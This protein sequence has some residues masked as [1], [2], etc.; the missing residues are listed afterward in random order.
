MRQVGF[1]NSFPTGVWGVGRTRASV[2]S[3]L[4]RFTWHSGCNSEEPGPKMQ[5]LYFPACF[6]FDFLFYSPFPSSFSLFLFLLGWQAAKCSLSIFS[7]ALRS[8]WQNKARA[9]SVLVHL[10]GPIEVCRQSQ[11][12]AGPWSAGAGLWEAM[13]SWWHNKVLVLL[14]QGWFH[15][16]LCYRCSQCLNRP[17]S[18]K[19]LDFYLGQYLSYKVVER[20]N[21]F[22]W[23]DALRCP[24]TYYVSSEHKHT[25]HLY[26]CNEHY[27]K[28]DVLFFGNGEADQV[29]LVT[30]KQEM[31]SEPGARNCRTDVPCPAFGTSYEYPSL[32]ESR[33]PMSDRGGLGQSNTVSGF[34]H[35]TSGTIRAYSLILLPLGSEL[36]LQR[37]TCFNI[38]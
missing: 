25:K 9:N 30:G 36:S 28:R 10:N 14:A 22:R 5:E 16:M 7:V 13:V 35:R 2:R 31:P 29:V 1:Q 6:Y 24:I 12:G 21:S 34:L 38:K 23:W 33:P 19:A 26:N 11:H 3:S 20:L 18:C 4:S 17:R 15:L 27:C 32:M 8:I 37:T